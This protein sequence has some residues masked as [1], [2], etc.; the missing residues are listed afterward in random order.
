MPSRAKLIDEL[1]D[2]TVRARRRRLNV[3]GT[4]DVRLLGLK[5]VDFKIDRNI[6]A[7]AIFHSDSLDAGVNQLTRMTHAPT[8][9]ALVHVVA[10]CAVQSVSTSRRKGLLELL[11]ERYG[12]QHRSALRDAW[13]FYPMGRSAFDLHSQGIADMLQSSQSDRKLMAMEL[14]GRLGMTH[15]ASRIADWVAATSDG[16]GHRIGELALCRMG[17]VSETLPGRIEQLIRGS[18][19]DVMHAFRLMASSGRLESASSDQLISWA[20][21]AKHDVSRLAWCLATIKNPVAAHD[22]V[23]NNNAM[24]PDLRIRI[25]ALAG[26]P[27][28]LIAVVRSVTEQALPATPA[29]IDALTTFLGG[30]PMELNAKPMDATQRD[31][32]LRTAVLAAFR[33]AHIPVRNEAKVCE[34]TPHAMLAEPDTAHSARSRRLRYGA[35]MRLP[36]NGGVVLHTSVLQMGALMRQALYIDQ[37]VQAGRPIG[38]GL[39][40]YASARHQLDV[41]GVSHWLGRVA[42]V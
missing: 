33:V 42:R 35:A 4:S 27:G 37:S 19:P 6:R 26:F 31:E 20:Q 18:E 28:G 30:V 29:Q 8:V 24:D 9:H 1:L 14:A 36:E 12:G 7:L 16:P 11:F 23:I 38:A 34:W 39:S 3:T 25:L 40:A 15:C 13:W 17:L 41:I 21:S 10:A 32:A 5:T 2:E 22:A